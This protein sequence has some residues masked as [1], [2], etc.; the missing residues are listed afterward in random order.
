M[1]MVG[2]NT[3]FPLGAI[4]KTQ[5]AVSHSSTEAEVIAL[6]YA[7]RVE[8]LPALTFWEHVVMLFC[9]NESVSKDIAQNKN[10]SKTGPPTGGTE[11]AAE[12][13]SATK[14]ARSTTDKY[15]VPSFETWLSQNL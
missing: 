12:A 2:P 8:G 3:F 10:P 11:S 6:D 5:P 1:A 4:S 15:K 7:I 13:A 9:T 14:T